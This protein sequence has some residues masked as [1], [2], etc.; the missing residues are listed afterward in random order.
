MF[1]YSSVVQADRYEPFIVTQLGQGG[2]P[3]RRRQMPEAQAS[4]MT[5][6]AAAGGEEASQEDAAR[7][8]NPPYALADC[9][10][11]VHKDVAEVER[12]VRAIERKG[13]II[14]AGAPGT[15]KTYCA[16]RLARLLVSEGSG[17]VEL[18]QFH[19]S[20]GYEDFMQGIRPQASADGALRY[21]LV[22]GRFMGFC[23]RA[24]G[25]DRSVLI[26]DEINRA[27][28]AR[29]LGELLYLLEYRS[30]AI[31]LAG[32]TLFT[33]PANVVLIGTMNT[34]DRSIALMDHALRRRFAFIPLHPDTGSL[35]R[36]HEQRKTGFDPG[37]LVEVLHRVNR[38]IDDPHYAVGVSFFMTADLSVAGTLQ[39]IWRL[40]I[41]PYLDELFF[42]QPAKAGAF[43]WE[44]VAH[45]L[46]S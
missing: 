22:A 31:P 13:Q 39:D 45:E 29:V 41:E 23:R 20:Y 2:V 28:V 19:P 30:R 7:P 40:E 21:P 14:F 44:V 32:G 43:R 33:I 8:A 25:G 27:N 16:E 34:A 3:R 26:I 10:R 15:G 42:D 35:V 37:R 11:D 36:F 5:N 1:G 12:W 4:L 17:I 38:T 9:A 24:E 6:G 18:V 46:E